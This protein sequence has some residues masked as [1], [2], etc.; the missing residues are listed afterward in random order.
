MYFFKQARKSNILQNELT[1]QMVTATAFTPC[2]TLKNIAITKI[3][4][5]NKFTLKRT[6]D[7]PNINNTLGA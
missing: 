4:L 5:I 3:I 6:F 7:L 1:K 2:S